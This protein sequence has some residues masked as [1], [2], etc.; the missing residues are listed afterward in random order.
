MKE[1]TKKLPSF[2]GK[3]FLAPMAGIT[4]PAF[5][6]LCKEFGAGLV[7]TELTS[8]NAIVAKERLLKEEKKKIT[9]FIEFSEK[10]RP[11]SIQLFGSDL[12]M[13]EKAVK[14]ISPY[15]DIIDYNMGCPAPNITQ[16]MAGA[17]LLQEPKLTRKIFRT[18]VENSTKPV[19]LKI[20]SGVSKPDKF[21][22][23]AKIAEE[24]G[25]SMITFHPRTIKQGYS[26]K[27]D[28]SLIKK[29]KQ[30]VTMP[31]V[32]N[33]DITSPEDTKR[34]LEETG[35]DYVMIGRAASSNPFLFTQVNDYLKTGK[36]QQIS[37]KRKLKGFFSYLKYTRRYL[38]IKPSSIRM[39]AMNFTKGCMG[40]RK[41]RGDLL[42]VNDVETIEKMMK[43]FYKSL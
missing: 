5:R 27:S 13:L 18:L 17:A 15:A 38:S 10:E 25:I 33:G 2:P 21:L 24:E 12:K 40:A 35:C 19:T 20:R 3:A 11:L 32:G 30:S 1:I 4:D 37:A 29:L 28:W 6:L 8:I 23:I 41:L 31:V 7:V 14:I 22:K 34:M 16:Q 26:G 42:G 43:D 39:Q 9:E 36:Y